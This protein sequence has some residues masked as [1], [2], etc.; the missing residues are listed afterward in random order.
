M[1]ESIDLT[2]RDRARP[3]RVVPSGR[4]PPAPATCPSLSILREASRAKW[5]KSTSLTRGP[6]HRAPLHLATPADWVLLTNRGAHRYLAFRSSF[7]PS[8]QVTGLGN[9]SPHT[10]KLPE[11]HE[12][13][14]QGPLLLS[15]RELTRHLMSEA[16]AWCQQGTM[17]AREKVRRVFR[18][19]KAEQGDLGQGPVLLN[20]ASTAGRT[21][22]PHACSVTF[23]SLAV[24]KSIPNHSL[25]TLPGLLVHQGQASNEAICWSVHARM[26]L[27]QS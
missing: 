8:S 11:L 26:T 14:Q 5:S 24:A 18:Q 27:K 10:D 20:K 9:V 12:T 19:D 2:R 16:P 15:A 4:Q 21:P 22:K 1:K 17:C 6:K 23:R 3:R 25:G 7:A 13:F